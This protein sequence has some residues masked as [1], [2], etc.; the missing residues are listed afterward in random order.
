MSEEMFASWQGAL[1][2]NFFK[3][4]QALQYCSPILSIRQ[5]KNMQHEHVLI[6]IQ[7]RMQGAKYL[8]FMWIRILVGTI[9]VEFLRFFFYK[10]NGS[11]L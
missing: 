6:N 2:F 11:L 5:H 4:I 1:L 9:K 3:F 7:I 8:Q 10:G